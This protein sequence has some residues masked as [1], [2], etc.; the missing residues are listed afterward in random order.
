[1][2]ECRE[3]ELASGL[4]AMTDESYVGTLSDGRRLK[5]SIKIGYRKGQ[6]ASK[7]G[8]VE[9]ESGRPVKR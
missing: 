7:I 2:Y 5:Y 8:S 4:V 9:Q 1:M 6:L 3:T